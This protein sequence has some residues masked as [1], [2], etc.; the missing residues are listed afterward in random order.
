MN[1]TI[2]TTNNPDD[3][4]VEVFCKSRVVDPL[5]MVDSEVKRISDVNEEWK[6]KLKTHSKAKKYFL[7]FEK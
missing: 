4:D 7:K 1:C 6:E 5:F 2:K 3:Y